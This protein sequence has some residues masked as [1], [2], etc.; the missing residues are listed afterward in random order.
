MS[1]FVFVSKQTRHFIC[2]SGFTTIL[3]QVQS[4][5]HII[6]FFLEQRDGLW[7]SIQQVLV[8]HIVFIQIIIQEQ[9]TGA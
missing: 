8:V 4:N 2:V 3:V 7:S 1:R 5:P 9:E 6:I